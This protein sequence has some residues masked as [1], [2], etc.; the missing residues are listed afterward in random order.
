MTCFPDSFSLLSSP[1]LE[2]L[3]FFHFSKGYFKRRRKKK[4][5]FRDT[6]TYTFLDKSKK[7]NVFDSPFLTPAH[8]TFPTDKQ[9]MAIIHNHP[10][11]RWVKN[12]SFILY[13][14]TLPDLTRA[15]PDTH[16]PPQSAPTTRYDIHLKHLNRTFTVAQVSTWMQC[17]Q[18]CEEGF[19]S[20]T[21]YIRE[22][23]VY[24]V[25]VTPK[26]SCVVD[27]EHLHHNIPTAQSRTMYGT[28]TRGIDHSRQVGICGQQLMTDLRCEVQGRQEAIREAILHAWTGLFACWSFLAIVWFFISLFASRLR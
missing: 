14:R 23:T 13:T 12:V 7:Q 10:W 19:V 25:C 27:C 16:W 15:S 18:S 8:W 21:R 1:F 2:N 24:L 20:R 11:W 26:I 22:S 17:Q 6:H 4:A 5:S 3:R 28:Q 9:K